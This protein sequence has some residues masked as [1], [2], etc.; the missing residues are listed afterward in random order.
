MNI[1]KIIR[2]AIARNDGALLKQ[3][4]AEAYERY[5]GLVAFV[6]HGYLRDPRDVEDLVDETFLRFF[7]YEKKEEIRSVKSFLAQSAKNLALTQLRKP[8]HETLQEEDVVTHDPMALFLL[9]LRSYLDQA[10]LD[11]LYDYYVYDLGAA[12]IASSRNETVSAVRMR[13][14]R[15]K[16]KVK[17][18]FG[19]IP[20]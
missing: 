12:E 20:R 2:K 13:I 5:H 16:K 11:L 17:E 6:L 14:A 9:D 15:L 1:E 7:A 18:R 19:G 3:A 10:E 8:E 4:Y